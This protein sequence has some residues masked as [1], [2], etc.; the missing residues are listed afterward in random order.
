MNIKQQFSLEN[1][2]MSFGGHLVLLAFMVT[3]FLIVS[4]PGVIVA[5]DRIQIMEIDLN[6]V[7]IGGDETLLYNTNPST[8]MVTE[9]TK[10]ND[11]PPPQTVEPVPEQK[12]D[13]T[14]V[15]A[16]DVDSVADEVAKTPQPAPD[17]KNTPII[18]NAPRKKTVV[19][20]NRQ[21]GFSNTP[22][23]VSTVDALRVALTRCWIID[24]S[25]PDITDIR[26]VAHLSMNK[27]GTVQNVWF[28]SAARADTDSAFSYVLETIRNAINTCQPFKMLP[29]NE[30][31]TWKQIRLT[32][33]PTSGQIM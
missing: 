18:D 4:E 29:E 12:T 19:R 20:V 11:I 30:F 21:T 27:N 25:R 9:N 17:D 22:L 16:N 6:A 13:E 28:E 3:T 14:N 32:F 7:K 26:A 10:Q 1:L 24:T 8:D 15:L 2:L 31:E 5:T 23:T 33:Y